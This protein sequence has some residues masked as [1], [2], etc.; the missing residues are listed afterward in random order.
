MS[1]YYYLSANT[2]E[3]LVTQSNIF[4]TFLQKK[5]VMKELSE[6]TCALFDM[7]IASIR[8]R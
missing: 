5:N 7:S 2:G 6:S 1:K 3:F 8:L 4:L